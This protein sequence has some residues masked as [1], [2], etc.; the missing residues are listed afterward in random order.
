DGR[1]VSIPVR[2]EETGALE[3][4]AKFG[5]RVPQTTF[6][7]VAQDKRD[8]GIIQKNRFG[9]KRRGMLSVDYQMPFDG[10]FITKGST[11]EGDRTANLG[12][13]RKR[14]RRPASRG[15]PTR[16][17]PALGGRRRRSAAQGTQRRPAR[18]GAHQ[19]RRDDGRPARQQS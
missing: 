11:H 7:A 4:A 8:D 12:V 5:V 14:D 3:T 1:Q 2:N 6:E 18:A 17:G 15:R 9:V 13:D 19:A 10:G 16:P